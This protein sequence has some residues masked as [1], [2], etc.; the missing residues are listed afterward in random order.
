M[1]TFGQLI[2]TLREQIPLT[3][4]Q[5]ASM[6]KKEDGVPISPQYLHDLEH[7]RRNPPSDHLIKQFA[8]ALNVEPEYLFFFVDKL[9]NDKTN[10]LKT[11]ETATTPAARRRVVAAYRRMWKELGVAA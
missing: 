1:T 8:A 3:Q 4:K 2:T 6:V 11:L 7:D 9:P 10:P 5:L